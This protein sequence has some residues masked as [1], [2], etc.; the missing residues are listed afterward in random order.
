M[1]ATFKRAQQDD[2]MYNKVHYKLNLLLNHHPYLA[3]SD[4]SL[5]P[6]IHV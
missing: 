2:R 4:V 5:D 1:C 6:D 3:K